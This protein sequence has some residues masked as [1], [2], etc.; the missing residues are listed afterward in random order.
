MSAENILIRYYRQGEIMWCIE[1]GKFIRLRLG[2]VLRL[3]T[4]V[5]VELVR[6][7]EISATFTACRGNW[8]VFIPS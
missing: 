4:R 1:P 5:F 3:C 8:R 7:A 2:F 6:A